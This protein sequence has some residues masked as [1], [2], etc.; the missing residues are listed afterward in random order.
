VHVSS[1]IV[2]G[3][4]KE[5]ALEGF[6]TKMTDS[7]ADGDCEMAVVEDENTL[8]MDVD[9]PVLLQKPIKAHEN[10][11][12]VLEVRLKVPDQ[13]K[14]D[15]VVVEESLN[16]VESSIEVN[17]QHTRNLKKMSKKS[18]KDARRA[19]RYETGGTI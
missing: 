12:P 4:T 8:G 14:K 2:D 9:E 13:K 6:N 18:R 17:Q 19:H 7:N 11:E 16:T 5:F 15:Q 1:E 3:F 10:V